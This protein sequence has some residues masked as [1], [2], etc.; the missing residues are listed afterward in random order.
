VLD[1]LSGFEASI[2]WAQ[3]LDGTAPRL[4]F[5]TDGG[6]Q[7][8]VDDLAVG[9]PNGQEIV[10]LKGLTIAPGDR[11]LVTGPSGAGKTSLFRALGGVWPFGTGAIRVPKGASVLVLPQRPYLPLG[12][13]RGALAYPAPVAS[14]APAEI[15]AALDAVGLAHLKGEL[16]KTA[17][18]ADKLSGGEQQR[19]SIARAL[20]QKPQWLFLDEATAALDEASEAALYR[21]LTERLPGSAIVSIGH[22]SS[23]IAFHGRFF[24]LRPD[25]SGRHHLTETAPAAGKRAPEALDLTL[26]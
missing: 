23:L 7:L 1:R 25:G 2:G 21:L 8:E 9:L 13:L 20:L 3:G 11:V 5:A 4:E 10:R 12:T 16:D 18:W 6:V 19:L 14:F 26:G 22:R 17:Y 15:E 24:E